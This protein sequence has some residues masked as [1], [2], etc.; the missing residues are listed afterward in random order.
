M[1]CHLDEWNQCGAKKWNILGDAQTGWGLLD[2]ALAGVVVVS[3]VQCPAGAARG[4]SDRTGEWWWVWC[5]PRPYW[6]SVILC[7][8]A[9]TC[10]GWSNDRPLLVC[11][12]IAVTTDSSTGSYAYIRGDCTACSSFIPWNNLCQCIPV[13]PMPQRASPNPPASPMSPAG[14][15]VKFWCKIRRPSRPLQQ[16]I[17]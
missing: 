10:S 11:S 15:E 6:L 3:V 14:Q 5:R 1:H 2:N 17:N 16:L 7:R 8:R 9:C 12:S 4:S 13:S